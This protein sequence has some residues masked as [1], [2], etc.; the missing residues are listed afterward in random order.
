MR[1]HCVTSFFFFLF[2][3]IGLYAQHGIIS[4]KIV[5]ATTHEPLPGA[6]IMWADGKGVAADFDGYYEIKLPNGEYSLSVSYV[7]YHS[8]TE[9]I[10]INNNRLV[11]D[12]SLSP[13]MLSEI[14]VV[15]DLAK[16]RETPVA[17][18]N[19][20]IEQ[21]RERL[22][23]QDLPML[24]NVT[25]GVFVSQREGSDGQ[26]EVRIRGFN[27]QNVLVLVDGVPMNDMHNGRVYWSNWQGLGVNTRLMQ[28]QRGLGASKLAIPSVGGS[29][30]VITQ[31]I[32]MERVFSVRQDYGNRNNAQTTFSASSG[33]LKGDWNIQGALAF[34][35]NQG[36]V[37]GTTTTWFSYYLKINK[38]IKKHTL[39]FTAFGAPQWADQRSYLYEFGIEA[40]SKSYALELGVDTNPS[41]K[42]RNWRYNQGWGYLRR[43]RPSEGGLDASLEKLN[44]TQNHYFKPLFFLKDFIKVSD[45]FYIS[46]IVYASVGI[47]GGTQLNSISSVALDTNGQI[48]LQAIY[49]ANAYSPFNQYPISGTN[50]TL[51]KASNFI[52]KN[53]NEHTWVG[54]LGTF[55]YAF[56]ERLS[57]SGGMD[58]RY[59]RG[60]VF[61]TVYNLLGA[62]LSVQNP[63]P[64]VASKGYVVE[65]DHILKNLAR[66]ILWGG[67]FLMLEY[68]HPVFSSF[69]NLSGAVT[70]YNQTNFF[71]KKQLHIGDTILD[72][73]YYDTVTYQGNMYT[74]DSKGLDYAQSRFFARWGYTVK[75]GMNFKLHTSHNLFFNAGYFSRAPYM[76]FLVL[77]NNDRVLN[78][79]NEN[80]ASFELG[81][82]IQYKKFGLNLNGYYTWWMN[83]PEQASIPNQNGEY[84]S[85][86]INGLEAVHMGVELDFVYK[87][88]KQ[89]A[90][91][92]SISIGDWH[93][94]SIGTA[95]TFDDIGIPVPNGISQIDL[96]GIKVGDQPQHQYAVI[97]RI[98]PVKGLYIAP[99]VIFFTHYY[100]NY[101]ANTYKINPV[102]G[103]APH[104]G[105]QPWR[106]PD[107]Y[108][109]NLNMGY[110]FKVKKIKFDLR[111]NFMNLTNHFYIADAF[112]GG[113]IPNTF[114]AN[115]ASVNIGLGF[116]YMGSLQVTF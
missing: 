69:I 6:A 103:I 2:V 28:V 34:K 60:S 80:L 85:V 37:D 81:Y 98:M 33:R 20:S 71:A 94:N 4:G 104:A 95:Q 45:K 42:E 79:Q 35:Y 40:Y 110:G 76:S 21:I 74:R 41:V 87:P 50:D 114:S 11:L 115:G 12:F 27:Q 108:I 48:N 57:L 36:W 67:G 54:A 29:I 65:G 97:I 92:G 112:D 62:D 61:S 26:A 22:G 88:I 7:S 102:T 64:N 66:D 106:I 116:R 91:E 38:Q 16:P 15:S 63:D 18:S 70:G 96:R 14:E 107:F 24:L 19:I 89:L 25:P 32:D 8:Q 49:D 9:R 5:D 101:N 83:K 109:M 51:Q 105:R 30:N 82:T 10:T 73:G 44:T 77:N 46:A 1:R 113:I 68:K 99:E 86:N 13:T 111:A 39:S 31:G 43:T 53:H 84:V 75:G 90:F 100:A 52:R 59:F 72:I 58:F 78:A 93:W 23:S 47:G 55:D 56:N 3:Q 17:F